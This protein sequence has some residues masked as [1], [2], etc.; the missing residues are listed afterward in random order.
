MTRYRISPRAR[1]DLSDIWDYTARQWSAEQAA[2][3]V[4]LIAEACGDLASRKITGRPADD[5]RE[6]Y[7]KL[8]V[9]SHVLFYREDGRTVIIVRVLHNRMDVTRHL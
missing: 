1:K 7:R 6:G 3:Y 2:R 4:R 8:S 5:I 9:G